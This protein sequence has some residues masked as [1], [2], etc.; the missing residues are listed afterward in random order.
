MMDARARVHRTHPY[1]HRVVPGQLPLVLEP[2]S[3]RCAESALRAAYRR[4]ALSR[5]MSYEQAM[6]RRAYAIGIRNL[7]EAIARRIDRV[8]RVRAR[9]R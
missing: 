1:A 2:V 3:A 5:R 9:Q 8:E 7:A 4:L 6:S